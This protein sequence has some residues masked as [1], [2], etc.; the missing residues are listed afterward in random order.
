VRNQDAVAEVE[1]PGAGGQVSGAWLNW[2]GDGY[3]LHIRG[4]ATHQVLALVRAGKR[5]PTYSFNLVN[6]EGLVFCRFYT[7]NHVDSQRFLVFC[8]T[9]QRGRSGG[10]NAD[11]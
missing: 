6:R 7:R 2:I 8:E 1:V 11:D 4:G 3:N 5:G 9:Y 10:S